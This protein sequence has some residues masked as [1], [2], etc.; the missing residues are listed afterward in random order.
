MLWTIFFYY[1]LFAQCAIVGLIVGGLIA[2]CGDEPSIIEKL[3]LLQGTVALAIGLAVGVILGPVLLPFSIPI[4][5]K[6]W[7]EMSVESDYWKTIQRQQVRLSLDHLHEGNI[8]PE[9]LEHFEAQSQAPLALG[10]EHLDDVWLKPQEP[11]RSK[12]R[13]LLHPDGITFVEIGFTMG[14]YYFEILSYLDDGTVFSSAP[15]KTNSFF[16]KISRSEHRY[17]VQCLPNAEI[18]EL[19]AKHEQRLR[20]LS[21]EAG[22]GIRSV[23]KDDWKAHF[24]YHNDR[25]GQLKHQLNGGDPIDFEVVFPA[26]GAQAEFGSH[27]VAPL[28]GKSL[29]CVGGN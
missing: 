14:L 23:E 27:S 24:Q 19:L 7:K 8:D 4:I 18:E 26:V 28:K 2:K 16:K 15:V 11:Y 1:C 29:D 20:Q 6:C 10:Y 22:I 13:L 9:L 5:R 21:E 12:A 17:Y 25:F 3:G